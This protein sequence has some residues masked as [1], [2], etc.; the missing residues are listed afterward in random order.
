MPEKN[1]DTV[2]ARD[3][4]G[5][6]GVGET[7]RE[8]RQLAERVAADVTRRAFID[9]RERVGILRVD[10]IDAEIEPLGD[11]ILELSSELSI[12]RSRSQQPQ[13]RSPSTRSVGQP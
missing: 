8:P 13:W 5:G 6:E 1:A 7:V 3:A 4:D 12:R 9:Q 10:G 11:R 2:A